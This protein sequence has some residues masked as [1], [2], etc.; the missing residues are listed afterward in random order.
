V[1]YACNSWKVSAKLLNSDIS[2]PFAASKI[3]LNPVYDN[4]L[5]SK[6][7]IFKLNSLDKYRLN[8]LTPLSVIFWQ[9]LKL[10]LSDRRLSNFE[11]ERLSF[12]RPLSV[13]WEHNQKFISIC[14]S[15]VSSPIEF[16]SRIKASS[17]MWVHLFCEKL[18]KS[19]FTF[20]YPLKFNSRR[21]KS[22]NF[23]RAWQSLSIPLSVIW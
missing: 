10:S 19:H 22:I 7:I 12:P 9:P 23:E 4:Y 2:K 15:R 5:N 13:I 16:P 1:V 6:F 3:T 17:V 18:K 20:T 11:N 14:S 21:F 8:S